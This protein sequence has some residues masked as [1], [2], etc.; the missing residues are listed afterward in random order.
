MLRKIFFFSYIQQ[1]IIRTA[2]YYLLISFYLSMPNAKYIVN[3]NDSM[4]VSIRKKGSSKG[5]KYFL[6]FVNKF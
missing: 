1:K 2:E 6:I 5:I 3:L 4:K